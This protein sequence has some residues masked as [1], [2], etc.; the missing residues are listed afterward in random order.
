MFRI[1]GKLQKSPSFVHDNQGRWRAFT[2]SS[3]S[4]YSQTFKLLLDWTQEGSWEAGGKQGEDR[5][6]AD[7]LPPHCCF[8]PE[9]ASEGALNPDSSANIHLSF[10][11]LHI[12]IR[13]RLRSYWWSL[14]YL[15]DTLLFHVPQH[16]SLQNESCLDTCLT[17]LPWL[18]TLNC[19]REEF[20]PWCSG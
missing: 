6:M 20:L 17:R 11:S 3:L 16:S 15:L 18:G 7:H 4:V 10:S 9:M 12:L 2:L 19:M 13:I 14:K 8:S 1:S 5:G